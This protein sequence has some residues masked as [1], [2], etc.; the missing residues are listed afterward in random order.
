MKSTT[1]SSVYVSASCNSFPNCC[2]ISDDNVVCYGS[3]NSLVLFKLLNK[4]DVKITLS[5]HSDK[6]NNVKWIN[7]PGSKPL[8]VS[9]SLDKCLALW[10]PAENNNYKLELKMVCHDG[11]ITCMDLLNISENLVYIVTTSADCTTKIWKMNL[12]AEDSHI[13]I[14]QLTTIQLKNQLVL[15]LA[16]CKLPTTS[17][18]LLAFGVE[19][20]K[21][22][23][24]I[25]NENKFEEVMVLRGHTEWINGLE[26]VQQDERNIFLASGSQDSYIR[27][28]RIESLDHKAASVDDN[29]NSEN[30]S[31]DNGNNENDC[32]TLT[33]NIITS[34][35]SA[36]RFAVTLESVLSGHE[37]WIYSVHWNKSE[38]NELRLI[39]SSMDKTIIV[40]KVDV[41]TG[42]WIEEIR[43]GEIGG[44]NL[45]FYGA[46]MTRSGGR[47]ILGHGFR[48]SFHL[49]SPS[50]V[51]GS[52]VEI[53][54]PSMICGGH[55]SSVNDL[56]WNKHGEYLLTVS[57]D[58]TTRLHAKWNDKIWC[59]MARPQVHGYDLRC[60]CSIDRFR[61]VSGA[62]EKILR[63]FNAP[64][65]F[66]LNFSTLTTA[67]ISK[68][69]LSSTKV[70]GACV[71]ALGLS[72][73]SV[74]Q[75][76][77]PP[78]EKQKT[79]QDYENY[80]VPQIYLSPPT[81]DSL[82]QNTLWPEEQKL[83]G[84]G[85]EMYA[86]DCSPDGKVVASACKAAKLEHACIIIWEAG[87]WRQVCSLQHH[88]LTVTQLAFSH[89]G[90]LL[91]SISR[92]RT[93]ALY[94]RHHP[95]LKFSKV[96]HSTKEMSVQSRIL[97]A[98]CW[99][100]DDLY[101]AT[102]S[103]DK[104]VAMWKV[105]VQSDL[106]PLDTNLEIDNCSG[107][108][109]SC[110]GTN[111]ANLELKVKCTFS[112]IL[113]QNDS[114]TAIDIAHQ[115]VCQKYLVSVGL[116][117]G[118]LLFYLWSPTFNA[119]ASPWIC[120]D[121]LDNS[122]AHHMA[123]KRLRFRPRCEES[124]K[125]TCPSPLISKSNSDSFEVASC[126]EDG[127]VKIFEIKFN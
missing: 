98:C 2:D 13:T 96:C 38:K 41:S 85:Y 121:A 88:T 61:Y 124:Q 90:Q 107:G 120:L 39:S 116:E 32:I 81:E 8:I 53:M 84:H 21:I 125:S 102:G 64:H 11:P 30:A 87:S 63:V 70:E 31:N 73:K 72:N 92:D 12:N 57:N 80:F 3:C 50:H 118:N 58:Q 68:E 109:S 113:H 76:Q 114:V 56:C 91:L 60:L 83:Y 62:D 9:S 22:H 123:V 100:H 20:L 46:R 127:A 7:L 71:P 36:L 104:S 28:W 29:T 24:F 101:F 52:S 103:R 77:I 43:L 99:S 26:F 34:C 93:W 106:Q 117:S 79:K 89:Q 97:W 14:E 95:D 25:E 66:L 65:N 69:D 16:I 86:V 55:F 126:S 33:S 48:G 45:G 82:M 51:L 18:V 94:R 40:W 111:E 112:S 44:S 1:I 75:H 10:K 67:V 119:D 49:W 115:L 47:H 4:E 110:N 6:V 108:S 42:L 105:D 17:E 23:L 19:D 27:I 35:Q 37:N 74:L 54:Q 78:Q 122:M 5:G 59:E 15:S